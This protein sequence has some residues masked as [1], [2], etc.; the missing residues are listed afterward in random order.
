VNLFGW[1]ITRQKRP[2]PADLV[3]AQPEKR[4]FG[5]WQSQILDIWGTSRTS[6]GAHVSEESALRL[7]VVFACIRVLSESVASL[8]LKLYRRTGD[9]REV[10]FGHPL[11]R[12][13][14][15]QANDIMTAMELRE[16]MMVHLGLWG[17]AY[18]ERQTDG[19]GEIVGLWPIPPAKVTPRVVRRR[20]GRLGLEYKI[21]LDDGGE[22]TLHQDK[23]LHVRGIGYNGFVGKSPI[24]LHREA[25]GM[26]LAAE[27]FGGKFFANDARSGVVLQTEQLLPDENY[28]RL[29]REWVGHGGADQAW[30]TKI[31]EGG[32]KANT[33]SMPMKDA[34]FLETRKYQR[35]EIAAIYR[36][37]PHMIGDLERATY[38]NIE[39][40]S[41]EFVMHTL[42]PWLVRIEQSIAA[43]LLTPE[44]RQTHFASHVVDGL[45]R[46]DTKSRYEAY[47]MGRQ[48]G[49]LSINDIRELEN[50]N[51]IPEGGDDYLQPLNMA[52]AGDFEAIQSSTPAMSSDGA[53]RSLPPEPPALSVKMERRAL[54]ARVGSAK[55]LQP[56]F[57]DTIQRIVR[58]EIAEIRRAIS[59]YLEAGDRGGFL[60]WLE[61]FAEEHAA[62][63]E[64]R[65]LPLYQSM[66]AA[67]A[68]AARNELE[69][70]IQAEDLAD[71]VA[72][73]N[74][75]YALR[76]AS[77]TQGQIAALARDPGEM[78][79]REAIDQRLSEWDE[80]RAEKEADWER[81]R[82]SNAIT[83][84]AWV[85]LGVRTVT[86]RNSG[87]E[88]CPYCKEMDGRS[89]SIT[90]RFLSAGDTVAGFTTRSPV[91]HPPLHQGCDC[92]L[93]ADTSFSQAQIAQTLA[94]DG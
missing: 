29:H 88:D 18:L 25:I 33:L 32:L 60:E 16:V 63:M 44:E 47:G 26:A 64:P 27:Q 68:D 8:P 79:P 70:D 93:E 66:A 9:R 12:V 3:I 65:M 36:V 28:Q 76:H 11:Y 20:A 80:T 78:E 13:L 1:N 83:K 91:G 7:A 34:Q 4:S 5:T 77:S 82:S 94:S 40:Q 62:W 92:F 89:A 55:T 37:P 54:P 73:Y 71:F 61:S 75:A 19:R 69:G 51:P 74:R 14:H 72:D 86:W 57:R 46:G 56:V 67:M 49:F 85:L 38:S 21:T 15:D 10:D 24:Q 53:A 6:A 22:K 23:V 45:L 41:L 81:Q 43:A 84:A 52:P 2:T 30:K 59:R 42:R 50:M 35:S 90:S 17:N 87:S 48:W 31:L 58:R 39:H